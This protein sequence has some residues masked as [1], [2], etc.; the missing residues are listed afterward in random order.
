[1]PPRRVPLTGSAAQPTLTAEPPLVS[2]ITCI[3]VLVVTATVLPSRAK[4][5]S[6]VF[7][8]TPVY[9]QAIPCY[10]QALDNRAVG[11]EWTYFVRSVYVTQLTRHRVT[12][13]RL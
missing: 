5:H 8:F 3:Y 13:L 12:L 2:R 11:N 1:M 4:R 6:L 10:A 9:L 7:Q